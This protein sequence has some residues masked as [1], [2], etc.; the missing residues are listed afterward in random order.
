MIKSAYIQADTNKYVAGVD[1]VARGTLIG[2]VIAACVVLPHIFPD[3]VYKEIKDSK[4]I[5]DKKSARFWQDI[6]KRMRLLME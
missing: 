3:D 4:K 6:L 5:V 1:E 2:P